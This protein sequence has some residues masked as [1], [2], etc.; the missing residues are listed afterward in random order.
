MAVT[1]AALCGVR[2]RQERS[3]PKASSG[4]HVPLRPREGEEVA[5]GALV[6]GSLGGS[7]PVPL[8]ACL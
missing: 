5:T 3:L 8:Q 1:A 4:L 2:R 7:G 6:S